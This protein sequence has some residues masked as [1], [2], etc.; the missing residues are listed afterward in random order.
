MNS[1]CH[2][3]IWWA[4]KTLSCNLRKMSTIL[5]FVF[6][7]EEYKL[8]MLIACSET[9]I[10]FITMVPYLTWLFKLFSIFFFM[11]SNASQRNANIFNDSTLVYFTC[12]WWSCTCQRIFKFSQEE[13]MKTNEPHN[14]NFAWYGLKCAEEH[15][16]L[17]WYRA[18]AWFRSRQ[19]CLARIS[20]TWT[21][22]QL[23]LTQISPPV[24]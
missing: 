5:H 19:R 11:F 10:C 14:A 4:M 6:G 2:S 20:C 3:I 7:E 17:T 18:G 16:Y 8:I 13:N 9:R 15:S 12:Q 21:Y 24:K 1:C 22:L 23:Y